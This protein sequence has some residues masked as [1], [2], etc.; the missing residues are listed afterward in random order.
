MFANEH[1]CIVCLSDTHNAM[2]LYLVDS[3]TLKKVS[4]SPCVQLPLPLTFPSNGESQD[5]TLYVPLFRT[6]HV[7]RRL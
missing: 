2:V 7:R 3:V 5:G 6:K 4:S 1:D